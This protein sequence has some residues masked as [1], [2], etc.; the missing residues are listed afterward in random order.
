MKASPAPFTKNDVFLSCLSNPRETENSQASLM[1]LMMSERAWLAHTNTS[2]KNKTALSF[3]S[4][5]LSL[6][7]DFKHRAKYAVDVLR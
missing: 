1:P 6:K 2:P 5:Q 3:P 4:G 7:E